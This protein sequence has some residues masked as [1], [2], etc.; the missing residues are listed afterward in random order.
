[1][2][3]ISTPPEWDE[4]MDVYLGE[5]CD[6][7]HLVQTAVPSGIKFNVY[8]L[9][10]DC[11]EWFVKYQV[12]FGVRLLMLI[13]ENEEREEDSFCNEILKTAVSILIHL[14]LDFEDDEDLALL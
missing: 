9:K 1:M 11:S 12:D 7:L 14:K 2:S 6:H 13:P 5:S 3:T 8:E 4:S 10:R